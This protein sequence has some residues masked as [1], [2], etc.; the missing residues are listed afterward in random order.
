MMQPYT[1]SSGSLF[2][3]LLSTV[4]SS[5][6]IPDDPAPSSGLPLLRTRSSGPRPD[7]PASPVVY[8]CQPSD[9]PALALHLYKEPTVWNPRP[10]LSFI[11]R[12]LFSPNLAWR[13][14]DPTKISSC[15]LVP[16]FLRI[17]RSGITP[18]LCFKSCGKLKDI[19]SKILSP[20][21]LNVGCLR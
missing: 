17:G 13:F 2:C 15:P 7:D 3:Y 6:P 16:C 9:H 5:D 8:L 20:R 18:E 1:G 14:F 19:S 11:R 12:P 21:S 10:H 4:G